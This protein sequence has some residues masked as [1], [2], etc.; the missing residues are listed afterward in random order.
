VASTIRGV[1]D[2]VIKYG[3]VKRKS[4]SV[5]MK[6]SLENQ[7]IALIWKIPDGVGWGQIVTGNGRGTGI[8]L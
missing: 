3:K 4:E 2:F 8:R 5:T 6:S 7:K 1:E